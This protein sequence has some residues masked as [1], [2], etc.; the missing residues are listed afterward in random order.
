MEGLVVALAAP[1]VRSVLTVAAGVVVISSVRGGR[2]AAGWLDLE[3]H[4][5]V[6]ATSREDI[7]AGENRAVG[8]RWWCFASLPR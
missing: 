4:H 6:L 3:I 5:L 7:V 8:G 2:P 1:P